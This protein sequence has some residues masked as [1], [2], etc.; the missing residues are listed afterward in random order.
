MS[1]SINQINNVCLCNAGNKTC[2]Y[3]YNDDLDDSKWFCHK[4]RPI[5]KTKIDHAIEEFLEDCKKRKINPN[6][7]NKPLGDNC[8]GYLLLKHIKQ[9]YDCD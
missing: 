5:E 6:K 4:L 3:L 9:G 2:R 7:L 1:L 8:D